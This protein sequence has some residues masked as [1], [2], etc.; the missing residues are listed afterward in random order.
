LKVSPTG[1]S[2]NISPAKVRMVASISRTLARATIGA[3]ALRCAVCTGGSV[4]WN[5]RA[6]TP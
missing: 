6:S 1:N 2:S 3:I 4:D 5:M